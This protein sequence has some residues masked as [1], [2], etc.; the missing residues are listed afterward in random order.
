VELP[1]VRREKLT[2]LDPSPQCPIWWSEYTP[3]QERRH[4]LVARFIGLCVDPRPSLLP[5]H[6]T[7]TSLRPF[8]RSHLIRNPSLSFYALCSLSNLPNNL[9]H[10]LVATYLSPSTSAALLYP[11]EALLSKVE[12]IVSFVSARIGACMS[13]QGGEGYAGDWGVKAGAKVG[14]LF[15][16]LSSSFPSTVFDLGTSRS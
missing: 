12:L 9:H 14:A 7:L 15:C 4:R 13:Q 16:E 6:R 2:R 10:A 11:R 8:H 5:L 3:D 1:D